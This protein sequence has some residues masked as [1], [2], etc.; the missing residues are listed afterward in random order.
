MIGAISVLLLMLPAAETA[1]NFETAKIEAMQLLQTGRYQ[2][3]RL[4]AA[5]LAK[6]SPDD[7]E[8][9]YILAKACR[10]LG[11]IAEAEKHAQWMLDLRPEYANGL[12]EAGLLREQFKD[13]DG[14]LDLLNSVYHRTPATQPEVRAEILA[15]I[16]RIFTKQGK[17]KDAAMLRAEILKLKEKL[18]EQSNRIATHN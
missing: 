4:K 10:K 16:A 1:G 2:E 3:A 6:A 17:T 5:P 11:R 18:H 12:W 13:L 15:D 8:V 7:I 14:A 9:F